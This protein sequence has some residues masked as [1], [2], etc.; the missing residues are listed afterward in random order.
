MEDRN[1]ELVSYS[2]ETS[3]IGKDPLEVHSKFKNTKVI[4]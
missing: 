1:K 4:V 2:V 3:K